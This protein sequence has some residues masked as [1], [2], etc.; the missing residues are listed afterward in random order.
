MWKYVKSL[1]FPVNIKT[2]DLAF[3]KLMVTQIG[4]YAGELNAALRYLNQR[5]SMPTDEGKALLTEIATEELAHVEILQAMMYQL[6]KGATV[7]ELKASGLD[8]NFTEHGYNFYPTDANGVPYTVQYYAVTGDPIADLTENL[9][10]EEKAR[11][12]YEHLMTLTNN[13]DI[14]APLAFLRQ[15]EIIH[16]QRFGELLDKYN[17]MK[18][19]NLI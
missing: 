8:A 3:A 13:K 2:K 4:G 7:Q 9:A 19:R 6:V 5:Y 1:E 10:A 16:Y 15:R 17:E 18:Q 14:L 11:V 12:V